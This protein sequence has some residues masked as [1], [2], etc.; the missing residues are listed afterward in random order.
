MNNL[1][2][3]EKVRIVPATA[4]KAIQAGRLK[5]KTDINPMWRIKMLTELFG[6][7]GV[8]WKAPIKHKEFVPGANGEVACFV[9]IELSIKQ[10]GEWSEP[11]QGT[12]G[13]MFVVKETK[14]FY[15]DD[16][17]I[18]KAYTDAISV[19][20]KSLG[21]GADVY[22]QSDSTKYSERNTGESKQNADILCDKCGAVIKGIKKDGKIYTAEEVKDQLGG[23]CRK[24]YSNAGN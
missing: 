14:G 1:E 9:D 21:I 2:I 11:I 19:A 23:L 15:T 22:W 3:Y 20:C 5:G 10:D 24:C 4:Q 6:P 12:G 13:S 8:G 16:E 7:A 17:A 18:K